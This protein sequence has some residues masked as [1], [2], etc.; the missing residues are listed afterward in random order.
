MFAL[1]P[2]SRANFDTETPG[3][4]AAAANRRLNSSLWFGRPLR[5]PAIGTSCDCDKVVPITI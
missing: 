1:M 5:L 2:C 3:S 4:H